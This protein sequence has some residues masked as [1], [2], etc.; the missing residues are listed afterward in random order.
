MRKKNIKSYIK[1]S[2]CI[3]MI[4]LLTRCNGKFEDYNMNTFGP[5]DGD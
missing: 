1:A 5:T 2:A 4:S 3:T